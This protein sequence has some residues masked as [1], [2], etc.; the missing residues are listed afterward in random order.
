MVSR[1][2][3]DHDYLTQVAEMTRRNRSYLRKH[4]ITD[5]RHP[6]LSVV[7]NILILCRLKQSVRGNRHRA[8]FDGS[9]EAIQ[10]F[11][12]VWQNEH[13][14]FPRPYV[15]LAQ[16]VAASV[17]AFQQLPVTYPLVAALQCSFDAPSFTDI[18]IHK[19]RGGIKNCRK[20]NQGSEIFS[21]W[22]CGCAP[23]PR[24]GA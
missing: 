5:Q 10:E 20:D 11:G 15:Q 22:F 21:G 14:P 18:A 9:E 23:V 3:A 12:A 19:M 4:G 16:D 1:T 6:R 2:L 8:D 24:D 13:H 7:E 17:R